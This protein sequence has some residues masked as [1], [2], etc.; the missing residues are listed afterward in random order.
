MAGEIQLQYV[1]GKTVYAVIRNHFGQVWNTAGGA[2]EAFNA[3]N[4]TDYDV[5][6]TE[7]GTTGVYAG[8]FPSAIVAG[9]Y[10]LDFRERAGASPAQSDLAVGAGEYDWTKIATRP[11]QKDQVWRNIGK[12]ATLTSSAKVL[13]ADDGSAAEMTSVVSD[14]GT[15][16]TQNAGA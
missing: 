3:S 5:A 11:R 9:V 14:D 2:F 16:Q 7:Q 6:L 1:T 15:T 8:D 13:Y 12:K 4:Y 10:S